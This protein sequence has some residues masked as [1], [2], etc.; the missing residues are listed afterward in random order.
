MDAVQKADSVAPEPSPEMP[1]VLERCVYGF[2]A[3]RL[4][5]AGDE[6][7]IFNLLSMP[8]AVPEIASSLNLDAEATER[9][10]VAA[11]A[12]GLLE[13]SG[14]RF[15]VPDHIRPYLDR[16]ATSYFG[17]TFAHFRTHT[18]DA[19][20]SLHHTVRTGIPPWARKETGAMSSPF[21]HLYADTVG[22]SA[23]LQAM[24]NLGYSASQELVTRFSLSSYSRLVD[25][26][27]ATG[28]FAIAA[29]KAYPSLSA[30]VF[31][32]P[33]VRPYLEERRRACGVEHRLTFVAGDFFRDALPEGDVY[34]LG[35]VLSDWDRETG[36]GI[37]KKVFGHLPSGGAVLIL[38]KLFDDTGCG[39]FA[40][41]MMDIAML[42]ET[43]GRH[44]RAGE[45]VAW[46]EEI[47]FVACQ[48]VRSSG[49][50]HMVIGFKPDG[51]RSGSSTY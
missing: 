15:A 40:T 22:A 1:M 30:V 27:G 26:G 48:V 2:L 10:L 34:A 31:D 51:I 38:E 7:G 43:R 20:A 12:I 13:H 23:F 24:W 21:H 32:L 3:S 8:L 11:C 18:W 6:L 41:A 25:V 47:G 50:K 36:T 37:L 42:L 5:F 33:P 9:F 29:L 45:Y 14:D 28:S 4:L 46:L 49:E 19:A 17:A 35:Y 44:R 39:P 16:G